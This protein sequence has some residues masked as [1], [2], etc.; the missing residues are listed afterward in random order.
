MEHLWPEKAED[1]VPITHI[2]NG[3][4]THTW[5]ARRM[6]LLFDRYLGPDWV[7]HFDDP[8]IWDLV[9]NI[10]DDQLWAVRQHLKRKLVA[11]IRECA[12]QRWMRGGWHPVAGGGFGRFAGSLM[13]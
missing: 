10:P 4:H 5:L 3:V 9:Y 8:E 6:C 7:E 2:T 11:Y 1:D 13:H 12:R